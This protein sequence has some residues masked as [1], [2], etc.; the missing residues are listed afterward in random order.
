MASI[1]WFA[2]PPYK[3]PP[4]PLPHPTKNDSDNIETTMM[5]KLVYSNKK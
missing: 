4:P 5:L 2:A 3:Q 1:Q